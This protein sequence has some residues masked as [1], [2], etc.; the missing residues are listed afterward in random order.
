M[1][2]D[3]NY[4]LSVLCEVILL[5]KVISL[6]QCVAAAAA[7]AVFYSTSQVRLGAQK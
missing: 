5:V 1:L 7:A 4:H 2:A 6:S 3:I